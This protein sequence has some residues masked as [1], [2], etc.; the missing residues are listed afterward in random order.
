[1]YRS[2]FSDTIVRICADNPFLDPWKLQQTAWGAQYSRREGGE[3]FTLLDLV[4]AHAFLPPNDPKREHVTLGMPDRKPVPDAPARC[5]TID[6]ADDLRRC[7]ALKTFVIDVDGTICTDPPSMPRPDVI[8]SVNAL[9]D[10]GHTVILETAR[11]ASLES[12]TREQLNTWGVRYDQLRCGYKI[13]ADYYVDNLALR[14][15]ELPHAA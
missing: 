11:R 8:A 14:P 4:N 10:A 3:A 7:N 2:N 5:W 12:R 13:P 1:M 6:T 9:Y 15:E